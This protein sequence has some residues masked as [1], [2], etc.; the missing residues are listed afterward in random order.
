M[1]TT[2]DIS[3]IVDTAPEVTFV[4]TNMDKLTREYGDNTYI[5]V[6]NSKVVGSDMDRMKLSSKITSKYSGQRVLI[7]KPGNLKEN[8]M[9]WHNDQQKYFSTGIETKSLVNSI[10]AVPNLESKKLKDV[11]ALENVL[12][13]RM[14]SYNKFMDLKNEFSDIP[15]FSSNTEK[16]EDSIGFLKSEVRRVWDKGDRTIKQIFDK[17]P[18]IKS[19][20][21]R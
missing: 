14:N 18:S 11:N 21:T 19:F 10:I 8:G 15:Y 7:T 3:L 13:D 9:A 2:K 1:E 4:L 5:A 20:Y 6:H 16:V 12:V 17:N